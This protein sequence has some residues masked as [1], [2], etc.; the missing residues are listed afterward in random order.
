MNNSL[1][2]DTVNTGIHL[3]LPNAQLI[4][5]PGSA[6][7]ILLSECVAGSD[8]VIWTLAIAV[9]MPAWVGHHHLRFGLCCPN[10]CLIRAPSTA[11]WPLLSECVPDS[12]EQA[13]VSLFAVRLDIGPH[14]FKL[15]DE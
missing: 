7:W 9:R 11:I 8:S 5:K 2:E 12:D 10:A 13:A 14:F 1:A 15:I 6:I 4:Y 3:L